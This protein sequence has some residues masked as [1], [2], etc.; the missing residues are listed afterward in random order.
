M[1]P[2]IALLNKDWRLYRAPI[3]ALLA[4]SAMPYAVLWGSNAFQMH[5]SGADFSN[6]I[7]YEAAMA[8]IL[9]IVAVA[10]AFGGCSFALERR[11]RS[12][13]FLAMLPVS[14][15]QIMAS[16]VLV[17]AFCLATVLLIHLT[18]YSLQMSSLDNGD[19]VFL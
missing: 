16:K 12:A 3:I 7:N 9:A 4:V 10:S 18:I 13:D 2:F 17:S 1:T 11:D 6:S 5:E 14:R 19:S 15:W 8:S